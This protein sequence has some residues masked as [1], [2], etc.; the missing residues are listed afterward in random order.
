M[1]T[2]LRIGGLNYVSGKWE[3][4]NTVTEKDF[5]SFGM[6][7]NLATIFFGFEMKL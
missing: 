1:R 3:I 6:N 5:S 4:V 7:I 2:T